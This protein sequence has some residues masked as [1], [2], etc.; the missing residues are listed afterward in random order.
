MA[1][2]LAFG[3]TYAPTRVT[4]PSIPSKSRSV[5]SRRQPRL[6]LKPL[7]CSTEPSESTSS[8]EPE[9]VVE[10]SNENKCPT[11]GIDLENAPGG[12]DK[13]G[14]VAG[15]V[16]AIAAFSWWPIKAYK[17]CPALE[18]AGV[19]YVRKG[20]LTNDVLFGRADEIEL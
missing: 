4:A 13:L 19:A 15:G 1:P 20:Q 10:E 6:T 2:S 7:R 5:S 12:C 16:G 11:C 17:P 9:P 14:R 3:I 8:S 18:E